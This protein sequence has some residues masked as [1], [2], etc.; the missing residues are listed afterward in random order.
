VIGAGRLHQGP[1]DDVAPDRA[2]QRRPGTQP[3]GPPGG[4]RGG[5]AGHQRHAAG[6]VRAGLERLGG[7]QDDVEHQVADDD[8]ASATSSA[9]RGGAQTRH[10]MDGT[11][12]MRS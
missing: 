9:R 2:D 8:D 12:A 3:A 10:A 11:G 7:R 4:V 1:P 6:D 5:A